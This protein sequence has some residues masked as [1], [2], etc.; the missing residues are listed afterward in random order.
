MRNRL[1]KGLD[2]GT[3]ADEITSVAEARLLAQTMVLEEIKTRKPW[4]LRRWSRETDPATHEL[5]ELSL[6]FLCLQHL[7]HLLVAGSS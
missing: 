1:L 6:F 4:T 7:P 3:I 5:N 2:T